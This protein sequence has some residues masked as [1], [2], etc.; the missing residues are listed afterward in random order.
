MPGPISFPR[1]VAGYDAIKIHGADIAAAATLDLDSVTGDLIDVTGNTTITA[2]TLANGRQRMV[3]FTGTPAVSH[4]GTNLILQGV[5]TFTAA[6][7]D[8]AIF[9]GYASG[10]VRGVFFPFSG[11]ALVDANFYTSNNATENFIPRCVDDAINSGFPFLN[12][13]IF[14][15]GTDIS[16]APLGKVDIS[17]TSGDAISGAVNIS[18]AQGGDV[19]VLP[20]TGDVNIAPIL[21]DAN[22][23]PIGNVN[24][25]GS[26]GIFAAPV[27]GGNISLTV[28]LAQI[29]LTGIPTS[30][31]S[32]SGALWRD[33][34][35]GLLHISP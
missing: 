30:D 7:G 26:G 3:R 29:I 33:T 10:V 35:T 16:I 13:S 18:P 12:S 2:I 19:N 20:A 15:D 4:D 8:I 6:P 17:P 1:S 21:G 24:M 27:R 34:I 31:P 25:I 23:N 9:R 5:A 28:D 11:R 22:I 14:D 32:V